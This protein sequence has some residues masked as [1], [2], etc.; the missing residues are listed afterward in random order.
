LSN[1][2]VFD[3]QHYEFLNRARGEVVR[4]LLDDVTQPL[5]LRTAVD[6]GCGLG[7]F[8]EMLQSLGLQVVGVDGRKENA[9]E[10]SRRVPHVSFHTINAEDIEIRSLGVFDLC[11]CFGLLYHLENPFIAIRHL[12]AMTRS[13]LLVEGLIYPGDQ[14]IMGLVEETPFEDQGLR[15]FAFYPTESCLMKMM[16]LA[17]FGNVYRL[18]AAPDHPDYHRQ[19]NAPKKRTILAASHAPLDCSL[20]VRVSEPASAIKPWIEPQENR[21]KTSKL[22][23]FA[24]K[25]L[26]QKVESIKRLVR[27]K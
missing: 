8:S 6:I 2:R 5:C 17:G 24:T 27:G 11:F 14:P 21:T 20:L 18:A 13:L 16:Y 9:E 25:P 10:A 26:P 3:Y 4:E 7:H 23:V 22:R 12:H 1:P 15:N 19:G